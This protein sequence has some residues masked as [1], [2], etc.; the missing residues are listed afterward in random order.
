M[1]SLDCLNVMTYDYHGSWEMQ[2]NLLHPWNDP[3]VSGLWLRG[4]SI[5]G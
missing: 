4:G 5:R 3:L 2:V 1:N